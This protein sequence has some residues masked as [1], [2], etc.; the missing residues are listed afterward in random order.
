[1]KIQTY[2]CFLVFLL[3]LSTEVSAQFKSSSMRIDGLTCSMCSNSVEKLIRNLSFVKNVTMN[4][5]LNVADIDFK[6]GE[7]VDISKLAKAVKDAGYSVGYLD[8][9]FDF[10]Q[11]SVSNGYVLMFEGNGYRFVGIDDQVLNGP[12]KIR[13]LGKEFQ[14]K[15]NYL[16]TFP[17]YSA[18]L[19]EDKKN[20]YYY[21][22]L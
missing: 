5:N 12:V 18:Y 2:L 10:K 19:K 13:F 6:E 14:E 4:L 16:T 3:L 7:K 11:Q 9:V 1:M 22:R 20:N 8:A 17:L 15:K 21:V